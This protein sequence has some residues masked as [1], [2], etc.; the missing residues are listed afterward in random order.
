V[1][2]I[3]DI[4]ASRETAD[5]CLRLSDRRQ[6]GRVHADSAIEKG[7]LFLTCLGLS[8]FLPYPDNSAVGGLWLILVFMYDL[9]H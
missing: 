3:S 4:A 2:E 9:V 5:F 1:Q 6:N 7:F 8:I